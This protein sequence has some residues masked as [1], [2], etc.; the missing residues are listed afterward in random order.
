M[1]LI[2]PHIDPDTPSDGEKWVFAQFAT[3][4][5]PVAGASDAGGGSGLD[6][7][8][9]TVL[10]SQDLAH[11]RRQMEGEID[12]LVVAPGL[13]VLVIEVK[14][15]HKLRREHGLWYYGADR[16]GDPRGPFKQAS[17]A[18]HSLRER[19]GRQRAHLHGV[20]FQSV[21]CFPFIDFSGVSEEWHPWQVIDHAKLRQRPIA[22]WVAAALRQARERTEELRKSWFDPHAGEPTADQCDE[23]VKVLRHDFEFYESPKARAQRID[24]EIR[25]YTESQFEALDHMRRMPRVVFDGPAGT[26]KTLLAIEAARRARSDGPPRPPA[27]FQP[28]ARRVAARADGR[29]V[30]RDHRLRPHGPRRRHPG[31]LAAVRGGRLLGPAAAGRPARR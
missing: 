21:V 6:T 4:G 27:L 31:R 11:H 9:W 10:H 19:L 25:H 24:E 29:A 5:R 14:G 15:C 26:G 7:S 13:G 12:F 1:R 23:I 18:M 22:E 17:E 28:P 2:P 8:G 3:A 30:R 20:L 16:A